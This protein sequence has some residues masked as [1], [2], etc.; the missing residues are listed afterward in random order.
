M[1]RYAR[2]SECCCSHSN[3]DQHAGINQGPK[4]LEITANHSKLLVLISKYAQCALT[5]DDPETWIREIP[6]MVYIFE[7]IQA[8]Q[9]DFDYSPKPVSLSYEGSTRRMFL[10]FSQEGKNCLDDL[11]VEK[12]VNCIKLISEDQQPITAYQ[13]SLKGLQFLKSLPN[14]VFDEVNSFIYTPNAPHYDTELLTCQ[15]NGEEFILKSKAGYQR[16]S[17]V[18]TTED[19]SY[20]SSPYLPS[21]LRTS[22]SRTMTSDLGFFRSNAH[23]AHE[24]S[25]GES[26]VHDDMSEAIQLANVNFMIVEWIPFGTNNVVALNER[27]GA[28]DRCQGG[29]FT[30]QVDTK[31]TST[32]L[33]GPEDLTSVSIIDFDLIH[34]INFETE[35]KYTEALGIVQVE[36][37]GMHLRMDGTVVNGMKIEAI[38]E[39][40][41]DNISLDALARVLVD[42]QLDSSKILDDLLSWYQRSILDVVFL[43]DSLN[44]SKFNCILTESIN[45]RLPAKKFLDGAEY[46]LELRQILGAIYA[47]EDLGSD[48]LV[49]LGTDGILVMSP[50]SEQFEPL[51]MHFLDIKCREEFIRTLFQRIF[52]LVDTLKSVRQLILQ[53][54]DDPDNVL[55]IRMALSE[56]SR[57]LVLLQETFEYLRES[58]EYLHPPP[59]PDNAMSKRLYKVMKLDILLGSIKVRV[60]DIEKILDGASNELINLQQTTDI[61][62][63]KQLEDAYMN[64]EQNT[65]FLV[66]ATAANERSSASLVIMQVVLAG[67]FAFDLLDRSTGG[68]LN[69][70]PPDWA[71]S[72]IY[73]TLVD[74]PGVFS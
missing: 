71:M 41:A 74:P 54:N 14:S 7:G 61:I 49:L 21:I 58:T 56:A 46:E 10:N 9:L 68:T 64:V 29:L 13:I 48:E 22:G 8:E 70:D 42:V 38:M 5:A 23:R 28:L 33:K 69:I 15:F 50:N 32:A 6:I 65:K 43:G 25:Q 1:I 36:C 12:L 30:S 3:V 67:G 57:D 51:I 37:F 59:P 44:R 11:R 45:P 60:D 34:F 40:R 55:R 17:D 35:I 26:N 24:S 52:V 18:T 73:V 53:V 16:I 66:A 2:A 27:L 19:V 4:V 62:N 72:V 20:V 39:R 47:A 31:P 63:T